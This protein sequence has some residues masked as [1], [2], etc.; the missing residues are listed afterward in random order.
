MIGLVFIINQ[1]PI[2]SQTLISIFVS[3]V[4]SHMPLLSSEFYHEHCGHCIKHILILSALHY[5]LS[6]AIMGQR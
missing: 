4:K 1:W 6:L 2:L 3:Q 5:G